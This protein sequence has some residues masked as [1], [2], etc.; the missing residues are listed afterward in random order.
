MVMLFIV[1]EISS[2]YDF[3]P[4][5]IYN[6]HP[7]LYEFI[8]NNLCSELYHFFYIGGVIISYL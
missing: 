3:K 5:S 4:G 6:C 7:K 8:I 2:I 1:I